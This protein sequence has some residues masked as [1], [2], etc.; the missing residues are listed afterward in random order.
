MSGK[1]YQV[2]FLSPNATVPTSQDG[3]GAST[4]KKSLEASRSEARSHAARV[5][6]P[7][8]KARKPGSRNVRIPSFATSTPGTASGRS[9]GSDSTGTSTS[10]SSSTASTGKSDASRHKT[11]GRRSAKTTLPILR[12][13]LRVAK[14]KQAAASG[15]SQESQEEDL[16][17]TINRERAVI[18]SRN[19]PKEITKSTLDPFARSA[20]DLSVPDEHLLHICMLAA[21][22]LLRSSG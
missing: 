18:V 1:K 5:S 20:A 6:H 17:Q 21:R 14:D 12:F 4:S 19:P 7:G 22:H 3:S 13:R 16:E 10:P 8:A 15:D 11:E 9:P 2:H